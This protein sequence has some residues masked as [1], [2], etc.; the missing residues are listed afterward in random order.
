MYACISSRQGA[1]GT[2]KVRVHGRES[3]LELKQ[4][5]SSRFGV[6]RTLS[7]GRN[8]QSGEEFLS[9]KRCSVWSEG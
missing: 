9:V 7:L 4:A 5:F 6:D 8:M 3:Q 2:E 1:C